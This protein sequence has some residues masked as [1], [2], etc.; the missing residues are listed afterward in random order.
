MYFNFSMLG[1]LIS[2]LEPVPPTPAIHLTL[3]SNVGATSP[4]LAPSVKELP[5]QPLPNY[6][7]SGQAL[8]LSLEEERKQ[9]ENKY[10]DLVAYILSGFKTGEVSVKEVLECLLQLPVSLKLQYDEFLQSRAAHLS[11]ASSF[12]ELFSILSPFWNFL[13]PSLLIHL[14][15]RFGDGQTRSS[16]NEYSGQLKEFRMRN[17]IKHYIDM[18]LPDAKE[19]V[20]KSGDNWMEKNLEQLE[21]F[22]IEVSRKCR[23][24]RYLTIP[25][26]DAKFSPPLDQPNVVSMV[27]NVLQQT[28]Y[29]KLETVSRNESCNQTAFNYPCKTNILHISASN[30]THSYIIA[31]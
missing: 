6:L 12:D 11:Q 18:L 22:R 10:E 28:Q 30:C 3:Q 5:S 21:E 13:N 19:I 31:C 26:V 4:P 1:R 17:K 29:G 7:E 20:T 16:V 27:S 14:A 9:F 25:S 15:L 23:F 24:G 8:P 2:R